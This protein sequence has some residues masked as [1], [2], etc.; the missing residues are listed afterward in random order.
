[1]SGSIQ[2][3]RSVIGWSKKS[4][5]VLPVSLLIDFSVKIISCS[6]K[7]ISP[8]ILSIIFMTPALFAGLKSSAVNGAVK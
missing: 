6:R 4:A 5:A 2:P 8:V 3:I 1:M 7:V